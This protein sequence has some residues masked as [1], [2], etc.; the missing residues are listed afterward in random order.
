MDIDLLGRLGIA[1]S[2]MG[3]DDDLVKVRAA[4]LRELI[5]NANTVDL[6]DRI[7]AERPIPEA[8]ENGDIPFIGSGR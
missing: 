3:P 4:D 2:Q 1:L 8:D 5:T 7:R 6:L